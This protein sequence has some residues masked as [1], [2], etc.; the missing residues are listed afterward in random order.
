VTDARGVP[1]VAH[2]TAANVNDITHLDALV[3][4][5]PDVLQGDRG[6]DSQPHRDRLAA[7][8][9]VAIF[10]RRR[11]S[12]GRG[13]GVFRWV[14][15]RTLAWLHR[16]RRPAVRYERHDRVHH[17]FLTLG[18]ALICWNYLKSTGRVF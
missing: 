8:G 5:L 7:R 17:A 16:F 1:L 10:G 18:C 9:I 14:V 11:T 15:E 13:L 2:V 12:H 6:Y 4:D 3:A